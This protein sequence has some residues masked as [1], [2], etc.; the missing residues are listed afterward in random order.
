[1]R[2]KLEL[3]R[4]SK[5]YLPKSSVWYKL[6]LQQERAKGALKVEYGELLVSLLPQHLSQE[7]M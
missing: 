5:E 1:M 6:V 7:A 2:A 4:C 3:V